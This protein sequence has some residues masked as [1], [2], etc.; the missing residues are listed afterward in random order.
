M[1]SLPPFH[2]LT[3]GE[4]P[5][6]ALVSFEE[7][8]ARATAIRLQNDGE[9][10][11]LGVLRQDHYEQPM[12]RWLYEHKPCLVL[13][14][15]WVIEPIHGDTAFPHVA[16]EFPRAA[17]AM[18]LFGASW[19]M[20]FAKSAPDANGRFTVQ[21]YDLGNMAPAEKYADHYALFKAWNIWLSAK[22]KEDAPADPFLQFEAHQTAAQSR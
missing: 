22:H 19:Q 9:N 13:A 20:N 5:L 10:L 2:I 6:G 15:E 8:G 16:H 1:V 3:L 7:N 14:T 12:I 18:R 17:G 11:Q 21:W 4:V